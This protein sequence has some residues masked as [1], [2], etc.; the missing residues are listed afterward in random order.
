MKNRLLNLFITI[1][2]LVLSF[3]V[4]SSALAVDLGVWD[5]SSEIAEEDFETHIVRQLEDVGEDKLRAHQELI[6][7]KMVEK[8]KRP[9]AVANISAATTTTSRLYDP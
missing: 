4:V 3:I 8:I 1:Q 7:D 9:R 5:E 2:I 6:K